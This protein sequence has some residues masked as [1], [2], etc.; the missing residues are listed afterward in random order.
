M[1]DRTPPTIGLLYPGELGAALAAMLRRRGLTVVTTLAGRG[2]VTAR[3]A[4]ELEL[5]VLDD[6]A[7]VVARSDIVICVVPPVAAERVADEYCALA[8]R[9]QKGAIYL[10]MNS[11]GPELAGRLG[12]KIERSG[13]AFVDAAANGLATNLARSGTLFLSGERA[14]EV[15]AA[16]DGAMRV[17]VM[18]TEAGQASAMKMLLSGLSKGVCALFLELAL[19]AERRGMLPQMIESAGRIYPG[20]WEVAQRMLPTYRLHAGRRASEMAE[21]EAMLRSDGIEACVIAAVRHLHEMLA[22]SY[23]DSGRCTAGDLTAD[24]MIQ[25]LASGGVLSARNDALPSV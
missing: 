25:Q 17:Q 12:R 9:A 5:T 20:I 3:R 13:R 14:G 2:P 18:G 16:F 15:A 10:D 4:R 23:G 24:S 6:L 7:E 19:T 8:D 21:V 22:E 11:I 1:S